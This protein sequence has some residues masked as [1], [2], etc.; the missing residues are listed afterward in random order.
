MNNYDKVFAVGGSIYT[1]KLEKTPEI[2]EA[3]QKHSPVSVVVGAGK[4]KENINAVE[5]SE[6]D[7]DLIGIQAT[8]LNAK[9]LGTQMQAHPKIPET[10][11]E[12]KEVAKTGE[13]LVMGGLNPGFSTDAVAAITAE[14]LSAELYIVTDIDGVYTE[15]PKKEDAEKLDEVSISEL[16]EIVSGNSS[17]AGSYELI[18]KTAL[19]IIER[20]GISTKVIEGT[21]DN[22]ENPEDAEGTAI[23]C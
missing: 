7:K 1:S 18:D 14:L 22:L 19:N 6:G 15:D 9:T 13:D 8:R 12:V 2:A 16:R 11:E 17:D 20:S 21:I 4:L 3:L 23:T 5:A 10:A